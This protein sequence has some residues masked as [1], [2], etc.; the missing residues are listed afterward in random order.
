MAQPKTVKGPG[1]HQMGPRQK[2]DH[3]FRINGPDIK[4]YGQALCTTF[5]YCSYMYCYKRF[6]QM[7]REHGL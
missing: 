5:N 2:I 3:P 7:F 4:V 6:W 1:K